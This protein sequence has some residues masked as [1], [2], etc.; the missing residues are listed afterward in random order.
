VGVQEAV[1][2]LD[3]FMPPAWL[4]E[5]S[6]GSERAFEVAAPAPI[7]PLVA[8]PDFPV[9]EPS[10][11]VVDEVVLPP[12]EPA[13][14]VAPIRGLS[15]VLEESADEDADQRR[16]TSVFR[17]LQAQPGNDSVQLTI[18]TRTGEAIDLALPSASLDDVLRQAL[19]EAV[20]AP[21]P[22]V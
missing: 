1:P 9:V 22:V 2:F 19:Q 17:L 15:L 8:Q 11:T 7:P 3:G 20:A 18:R 13:P 10:E 21:A 6:R 16:L 5:T 14:S 12:G 4:A